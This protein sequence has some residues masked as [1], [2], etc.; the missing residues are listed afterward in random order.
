MHFDLAFTPFQVIVALVWVA[1]AAFVYWATKRKHYK[2]AGV[3][4]VLAFVVSFMSPVRLT[5]PTQT[6]NIDRVQTIEQQRH[7]TPLPERVEVDAT[8]RS[9][10]R[11]TLDARTQQLRDRQHGAE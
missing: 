7:R 2:S 5:A 4:V 6:V 8:D 10:Y 9:N 3:A 11:E 1:V